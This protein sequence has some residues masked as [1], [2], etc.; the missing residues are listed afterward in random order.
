M[1]VMIIPTMGCPANCSYCWS[2]ETT[3]LVMSKNT[4]DDIVDWLKDFKKEPV[5]FTFHGGEPLLAGYDF[6]EH[7]LNNISTKL[8]HLYPA[9]AIQT[10]LWKMDDKIAELFKKYE[11]PIGSSLDGPKELND[12]QR[13]LGYYEKTLKGYEIAKKHGLN[14]SFISTFTDYSIKH[15]EEIFEFFKDNALNLKIHPALPSIKSHKSDDFALDPKEYGNLMLYLLDQYLDLADKIELKNIDHLCKGVFMKKGFVC[16]YVDCMDST[17]AIGPDGTIYPCYRFVDM[18]EYEIGHVT[19]KPSF[20]ELMNSKA[21]KLLAEYKEFV[22]ED[23]KECKHIDYCR[24]G[25]PYN[26]LTISDNKVNCVDPHCEAYKM[27]YDKIDELMNQKLNFAFEELDKTV[28]NDFNFT[29]DVGLGNNQE[30]SGK[31]F[32][33]MDIALK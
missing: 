8:S 24:G 10:N 28:E 31:K 33:V 27:I 7:A 22:D 13:G 11:I 19:N 18:P 6:Y 21:E 5:T 23:C 1:H 15:K 4:M 9:Y 26:A 12:K 2:S 29:L 17:F 3:S 20:E 32:T 16:T 25:C 30:Q 14:V